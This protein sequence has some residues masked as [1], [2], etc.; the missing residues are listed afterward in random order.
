MPDDEGWRSADASDYLKRA[1]R[2]GLAWEL[3]RRNLDYCRDFETMNR[4]LQS[5]SPD[6][7]ETV[8]ALVRRWGLGFPVRSGAPVRSGKGHLGHCEPASGRHAQRCAIRKQR[9][10]AVRRLPD[11]GV[12]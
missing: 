4:M 12:R 1:Q 7:L 11:R 10:R 9:Q 3:L 8:L 6:D 2:T 5:G